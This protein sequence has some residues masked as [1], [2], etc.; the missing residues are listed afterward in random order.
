M[1][2]FKKFTGAIVAAAVFILLFVA[3]LYY[4]LRAKSF[5]MVTPGRTSSGMIDFSKTSVDSLVEDYVNREMDR[6]IVISGTGAMKFYEWQLARAYDDASQSFDFS[7]AFSYIDAYLQNTDYLVGDIE[8]TMAGAGKGTDTSIYGYGA[9]KDT[10]IFNTP[11]VLAQNL[12]DVGFNMIATANSHAMDSGSNGVVS[13]VGYLNQAGLTALGTVKT[14]G[15]A[16]Y[17]MQNIHGMQTGFIAYTNAIN[18]EDDAQADTAQ[19]GDGTQDALTE[20]GSQDSTAGDSAAGDS[21]VQQY[22]LVNYLNH[23]DE[24]AV[25]QMCAQVQQMKS[26]GAEIVVVSLSFESSTST[27][28]DDSEK[29]LAAQLVL[30]GADVIFGNNASVP[31]S[32][33]VLDT[34]DSEGQAKKAV[35]IYSMGNLLTAQQYVDGTGNNRD[36]GM[37]C[38]VEITKSKTSARVTGLEIIPVYSNWTSDDIVSIPVIE[39]YENPDNYANVLDAIYAS[40]VTD[41]YTTIFPGILQSSGL[42]YTIEDSKYKI[43]IE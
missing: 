24:N 22:A 3:C 20:D 10:N 7:S 15:D 34:T 13:T 11:E 43:S 40:R 19:S 26:E 14:S 42:N 27:V 9:N 36:M 12:A 41:A 16:R 18:V 23:Y 30:A 38:N 35:V 17:V 32:I 8:T 29:N 39:A 33:D 5:Y 28:A 31:Q 21:A 37:I 6:Q 1:N 25:T 4:G 2:I